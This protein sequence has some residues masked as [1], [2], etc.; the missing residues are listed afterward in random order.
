MILQEF[1]KLKTGDRDLRK[2][3]LVVG[4][5][6]AVLAAWSWWRGKP[7]F[8][9]SAGAAVPLLLLGLAWPRSLK[10]IYVGWMAV[11]MMLGLVVSTV[12]LTAFFYLVLTPLGLMAR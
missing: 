6:F 10:W 9:C 3:G 4:G 5:V 12:L 8:P 7:G 11:G 1:K 2:F